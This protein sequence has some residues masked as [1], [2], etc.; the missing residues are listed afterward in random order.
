[1]RSFPASKICITFFV[2]KSF[3][4][5]HFK[6]VGI[7]LTTYNRYASTESAIGGFKISQKIFSINFH[8]VNCEC[9]HQQFTPLSFSESEVDATDGIS[10]SYFSLNRH[11]VP[12]LS[13]NFVVLMNKIEREKQIVRRMI[14]LYCRH[15]LHTKEMPEEYQRLTDFSARRL[16]H[17]RWGENKP[18]CKN[19]PIHCYPRKE[20][21]Q[22]RQIMRWT[23]PR[24]LLFAPLE[25]VRHI[26]DNLLGMLRIN[27]LKKLRH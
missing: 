18:A 3:F 6:D 27:K 19:C 16:D 4:K 2:S 25:V 15:K 24:M 7:G 11:E 20:R 10:P 23:G 22:I 13:L 26:W 1:M 14:E 12:K 8:L 9:I 21:E 5:Q 17:C